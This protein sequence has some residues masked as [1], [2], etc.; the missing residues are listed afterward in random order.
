MTFRKSA[1]WL[2]ALLELVGKRNVKI[3]NKKDAT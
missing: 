3:S 2:A 1:F